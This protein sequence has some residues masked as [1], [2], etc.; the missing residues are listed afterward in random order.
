MNSEI[1]MGK[2]YPTKCA[3][4]MLG[5]KKTAFENWVKE[6]RLPPLQKSPTRKNGK[7][8]FGEVIKFLRTLETPKRKSKKNKYVNGMGELSNA[9][10]LALP[11]VFNTNHLK[12][13][14]NLTV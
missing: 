2:F 6:G 5:I 12:T 3:Q 8:Y 9:G 1:T 4:A 14:T 10:D 11:Y 7:G 13:N